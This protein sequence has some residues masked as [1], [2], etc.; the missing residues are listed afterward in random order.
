MEHFGEVCFFHL[1]Q[2]FSSLGAEFYSIP[3]GCR[4]DMTRSSYFILTGSMP[5][6]FFIFLYLC[7]S[8]GHCFLTEKESGIFILVYILTE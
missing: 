3:V 2:E 1:T 7:I 8:F 4:S 5:K 6:Y